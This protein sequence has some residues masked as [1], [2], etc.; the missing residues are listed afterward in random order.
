MPHELSVT[1]IVSTATSLLASII[2]LLLLARIRP[3]LEISPV[4]AKGIRD[5][6]VTF[7]VKV[8]NKTKADLIDVRCRLDAVDWIPFAKGRLVRTSRIDLRYNELLVLPR[9]SKR[10]DDQSFAFRF[11]T[12][13]NVHSRIENAE[14]IRFQII[15]THGVSG[16]SRAYRRRFT[17]AEIRPGNF[18]TGTS[19]EVLP[20][21]KEEE[22]R[23]RVLEARVAQQIPG[24]AA[25]D[26][27]PINDQSA[28]SDARDAN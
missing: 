13:G 8:V 19:F 17:H 6:E 1:I 4:I 14:L 9:L 20:L 7:N 11:S 26:G 23:L 18:E 27:E 10:D 16:F 25:R 24:Q 22:A 21:K 12:E 5:E 2:F 15:A 28:Q 3:K